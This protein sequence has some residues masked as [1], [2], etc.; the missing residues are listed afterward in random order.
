MAALELGSV[1]EELNLF[2]KKGGWFGPITGTMQNS[3]LTPV[4]LTGCTF[5]GK[6][7]DK[8]TG[9]EVFSISPTITNAAAGTYS[10]EFTST[11]T[12]L[13]SSGEYIDKWHVRYY[14]DMEY[15]DASN[16]ELPL[17][18]GEVVVRLEVTSA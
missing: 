2:V 13:L 11:Q 4:N 9:T 17:Y 8:V 5:R 6:V 7:R 1:G 12:A 16:R 10:F 14:W 3:D 15:V 18:W